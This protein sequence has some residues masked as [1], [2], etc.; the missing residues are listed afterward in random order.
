MVEAWVYVDESQAPCAA[1]AADGQPFWIGSLITQHPIDQALIAGALDCLKT[2]P[3]A[4]GVTQDAT[5]LARGFFHAS[6]DSKNAHSWLCRALVRPPLQASFSAAQWFFGRPDSDDY[7]GGDLHRASVLLSI[8]TA[9]QDDF[10]CIHLFVAKREGSFEQRDIDQWP[11]YSTKM[12]FEALLHMP[13][14]P[15]RFP[16]IVAKLVSPGEPGVQVCD[17]VLWA[18]QRSRPDRLTATG[19]NDWVNRLGL[20]LWAS[21]GVMG[22]AQHALHGTLSAGAERPFLPPR[23]VRP[24]REIESLGALE[25]WTLTRQIASDVHRAA[26]LADYTPRITHLAAALNRASAACES[27]HRM[28]DNELGETLDRLMVAF[29]LVCDT[30][31]VYDPTDG[32]AWGHAIEKRTLAASFIRKTIGLSLP[33]G[34]SLRAHDA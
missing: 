22:S 1:G 13:S 2:D 21:G 11:E 23:G 6:E 14:M 7:T 24:P 30:L 33:T 4:V 31:P 19:K 9:L 25:Q 12:Q 8:M 28:S 15:T 32:T 3:D 27:A 29:L 20:H 10:D 18:T 16:P 26:V 5:T 17:F 34:F